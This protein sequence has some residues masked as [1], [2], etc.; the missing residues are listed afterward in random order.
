M[1][2]KKANIKSISQLEFRRDI[3]RDLFEDLRDD[4]GVK[5]TKTKKA[6]AIKKNDAL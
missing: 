2:A 5:S 4:F 1:Y 3:I 6:E